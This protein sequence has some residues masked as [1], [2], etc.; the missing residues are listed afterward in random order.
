M[1]PIPPSMI[2]GNVRAITNTSYRCK[3]CEGNKCQTCNIITDCTTFKSSTYSKV[4][5]IKANCNCSTSDIIYLIT[6]K[7]CNIQY[8][9]ESGQNLRDRIN[10]HKSKIRT[11]KKLLLL[12]ISIVLITP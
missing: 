9:G 7:L 11:Y 8:V 3:P 6:C 5:N 2:D 4:F 10:N 12:Y 1:Y